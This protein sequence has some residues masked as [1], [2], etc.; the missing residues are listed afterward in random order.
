LDVQL[1]GTVLGVAVSVA[2][3]IVGYWQWAK[4]HRKERKSALNA[5][6]RN[7]HQALWE[8]AERIH[9]ALRIKG[10][11]GKQFE[12]QISDFNATLMRTE[13]YLEDGLADLS[14]RYLNAVA[15]MVRYIQ[16]E[17]TESQRKH[18]AVTRE[19]PPEALVVVRAADLREELKRRIRQVLESAT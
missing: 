12:R 8:S 17:G 4:G 14:N 16:R 11:R 9:A 5:A 18:M 7:A 15:E 10:L 19:L 1:L 3:L 6:R 2:G 13:I